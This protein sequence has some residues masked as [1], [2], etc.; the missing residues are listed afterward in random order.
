MKNISLFFKRAVCA[1]I[2]CS[3][4]VTGL[5]VAA[6]GEAAAAPTGDAY[7]YYV[8]DGDLYRVK[9][10]GAGAERLL[11]SFNFRGTEL[12]PAGD[13]LYFMYDATSTT[14]L[15]VAVDGSEN[16][17]KRF[18]DSAVY[19]ETNKD[20]IYYMTD[21]GAIYRAPA[22]AADAAE[23]KLVADMADVKHPRFTIVDGRIYYN[24]LKNGRTTWVASKAADGNGQVQWIGAG[25][26][27]DPWFVRTDSASA[28]I[29]VNTK[30]E[31]TNYSTDCMVLYSV[32]RKG[33]APKAINPKS[34]L[35]TNSVYSGGWANKY[36]L[37]NK[38]IVLGTDGDYNYAKAKGQVMT[39][40]GKT[41]PLH[42]TGVLEIAN[43]GTDKLAFVDGAGKA[44]VSTFKN[45]KIVSTKALSVNNVGYVRNLLTDGKVRATMLFASSGAYMLK[46]DLSLQKMVG[47]EW[48]LCLYK[49]D[50]SGFF[51]VNAGD[52]GRLYHMNDDGKT[53]TKLSDEMIDRI[54]LISKQ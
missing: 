13:Y 48:D 26:F 34:P 31:E 29:M 30:P 32:P 33:G 4:I 50:V 19:F 14:L 1:F 3:L 25:A 22:N 17:P 54:V 45:N 51:Y 36:Y 5:G 16:I 28:Y 46:S 27:E 15:R 37:F 49:D 24:A 10:D 21:K 44:Y 52:N 20:F 18:Y 38:G 43:V 47:V 12:K 6:P 40:D 7:V 11:K 9:S 42:K 2:L 41:I 53:S 23:A 8:S 35:D 39:M